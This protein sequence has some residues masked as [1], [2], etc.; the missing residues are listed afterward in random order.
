MSD[1]NTELVEGVFWGFM[2]SLSGCLCAELAEAGGPEVCFCGV[3]PGDAVDPSLAAP[4]RGCG[5]GMAWVRLDSGYPSTVFPEPD[6]RAAGCSTLLAG[7]FEIGVLRPITL[8]SERKLP[9]LEELV[10]ATRLQFSDMSAMKR[11][12]ACCI[13]GIEAD[14]VYVLGEYVPSGPEGGLLGGFWTVTIQQEF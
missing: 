6:T 1:P 7:V 11:A 9:T 10:A 8:G 12:I 5:G 3:I 4:G 13:N 14:F 2:E